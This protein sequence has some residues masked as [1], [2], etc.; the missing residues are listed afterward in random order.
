MAYSQ[1]ASRCHA[2]IKK[3]HAAK[4]FELITWVV[5]IIFECSSIFIK[6]QRAQWNVILVHQNQMANTIIKI[7]RKLIN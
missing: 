5:F 2:A 6:F 3:F 4:E 1:A 7:I